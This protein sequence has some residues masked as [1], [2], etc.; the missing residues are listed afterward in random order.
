MREVWFRTT[1]CRLTSSSLAMPRFRRSMVAR[2]SASSIAPAWKSM[3]N[4]V[5]GCTFKSE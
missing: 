1:A 3:E 2:P 5:R 4:T